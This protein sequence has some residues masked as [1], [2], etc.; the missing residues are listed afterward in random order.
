MVEFRSVALPLGHSKF[1]AFAAELLRCVGHA[2]GNGSI[3]I[4][5]SHFEKDSSL[6][7]RNDKQKPIVIWKE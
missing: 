2:N 7:P 3:T 1:R 5:Q 6:L 4:A